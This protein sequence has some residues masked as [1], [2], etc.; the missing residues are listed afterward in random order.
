MPPNNRIS[1]E[2]LFNPT[3]FQLQNY[4]RISIVR[5]SFQAL[6]EIIKFYKE[7]RFEI[8]VYNDESHFRLN[9]QKDQR[10]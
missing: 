8:G 2:F 7:Q 6:P 3:S 1:S 5:L 4:N 9:F 10:L